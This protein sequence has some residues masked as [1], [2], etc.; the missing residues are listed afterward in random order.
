[1]GLHRQL[2]CPVGELFMPE[3]AHLAVPLR[4]R[5]GGKEGQCPDPPGPGDRR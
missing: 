2:A 5:Q 4:G 1:M 3:A